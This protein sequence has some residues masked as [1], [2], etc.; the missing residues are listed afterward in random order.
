MRLETN[1]GSDRNFPVGSFGSPTEPRQLRSGPVSNVFA[2]LL[3]VLLPAE[4]QP[5]PERESSSDSQGNGDRAAANAPNTS[6]LPFEITAPV[7][8]RSVPGKEKPAQPKT[9]PDGVPVVGVVVPTPIATWVPAE[10]PPP[11]TTFQGSGQPIP[12][13]RG[14]EIGV[15]PRAPATPAAALAVLPSDPVAALGKTDARPANGTTPNPIPARRSSGQPLPNAP[16]VPSAALAVLPSDPVEA[17]G[18]ADARPANGATP[19]PIPARRNSRQ[20]LSSCGVEI[21]AYYPP[22]TEV[23]PSVESHAEASAP[24]RAVP[25]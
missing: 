13:G 3:Q 12:Y 2:A 17:L 1:P 8:F 19:D 11:V 15:D 10:V 6:S 5:T 22:L 16:A 23:D 18:K 24:P 14:S 20:P 25:D 9:K 4:P 7:S 21:I